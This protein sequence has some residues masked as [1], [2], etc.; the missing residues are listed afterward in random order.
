[1]DIGWDSSPRVGTDGEGH[2]IV[3]WYSDEDLDG[4]IGTDADILFARSADGGDTWSAPSPLNTNADSD[5]RYDFHPELATDSGGNWV[6]VWRS[7][8]DLGGTIGTDD[9]ILFARSLDDGF[10][11]SAPAALNTNAAS[12]SVA[13]WLPHIATDGSGNWVAVWSS[14]GHVLYSV[15]TDL[16]AKRPCANARHR[17]FLWYNTL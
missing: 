10:T 11:W 16:G 17:K 12:D 5:T 7:G 15:S 9:D 8:D 13:D 1:L 14:E 6:A 3:V 2:W 4:A